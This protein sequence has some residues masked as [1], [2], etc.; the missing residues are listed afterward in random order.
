MLLLLTFGGFLK[1]NTT[2]L[3]GLLSI[4]AMAPAG[5]ASEILYGGVGN[6]AGTSLPIDGS[7]VILN[8]TNASPTLV[9]KPSG[10]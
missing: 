7:L 10:L 1:Q 3:Y 6:S 4:L 5:L 2:L 9:G 8:Q